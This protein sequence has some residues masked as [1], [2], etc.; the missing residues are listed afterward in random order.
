MNIFFI[1]KIKTETIDNTVKLLI[2]V[3]FWKKKTLFQMYFFCNSNRLNLKST[4]LKIFNFCPKLKIL[5]SFF[6]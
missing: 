3:T 2:S 4:F 6:F 1:R 5:I